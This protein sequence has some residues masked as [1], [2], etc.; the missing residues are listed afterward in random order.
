MATILFDPIPAPGHYNGSLQLARLLK[1]AGHQIVYIGPV[2]FRE[3]I[4]N[5]GFSFFVFQPFT[6]ESR[7]DRKRNVLNVWVDCFISIF[8]DSRLR[9]FLRI[10]NELDVI[11]KEIAPDLILLDSNF[12]QKIVL[13]RKC[14]IRTVFFDTMVSRQYALNVPPYNSVFIPKDRFYSKVYVKYL[15]LY[16]EYSL[17]CEIIMDS[18][19]YF[20]NASHNIFQKLALRYGIEIER[21][22]DTKRMNRTKVIPKGVTEL[23]IPPLCFDFPRPEKKNVI[24][25]GPLVNMNRDD[26]NLDTRYVN[27]VKRI[28]ELKQ[29]NHDILFI[30]A[31]LG[32]MSEAS[33]T[34]EKKFIR[35]LLE[36]CSS[37]KKSHVVFSV[38]KNYDI[39]NL[40]ALPDNL[41]ILNHVPQLD[42]LKYCDLMI[43]HGGMNTLTECILNNVPV[44]VYPLAKNW[45]Q[46]GNAARVVYHEIG[47]RGNFHRISANNLKKN[48]AMISENYSSYKE[49]LR[50]MNSEFNIE[51][52]A[53]RAVQIVESF[54]K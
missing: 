11:I 30:Y 25:I 5:A 44:I 18:I 2:E 17:R 50:K 26:A 13:Y 49:N 34:R 21:W 22:G 36:Y 28:R 1:Q 23:I 46:N 16:R 33:P 8:N 19:L 20:N 52:I 12:I 53:Q 31:S 29:D 15:W 9:N 40:P 41:Y 37:N 3:R 14:N 32:T 35:S 10:T 27:I 7:E 47:V 6:L 51:E 48:V 42:I 45:D 4:E 39:L 54:I 43:T 38:G 24:H